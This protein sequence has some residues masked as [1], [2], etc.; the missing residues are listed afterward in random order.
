MEASTAIYAPLVFR[1]KSDILSGRFVPGQM[2]G[3]EVR[4][5]AEAGISR[6]SVRLAIDDLVQE[7]LVERRAGKGIFARKAPPGVRIVELVV[8]E[9]GSHLWA[10][11][12]HGAQ[13]AG[14]QQGIKLQI[15]NAN[16]DFEADVRAIR[17]LPSSGVDGA[18]IAALHQKRMNET[19]VQLWQTGFPFVMCD[20]RM[21]D[22]DVPSVIFDNRHAGY[23]ATQELITLGHRR[24]GFLGYEV[25]GPT[26][27]RLEGYRDALNAAGILFD[28][29]L[30]AIQSL[31]SADAPRT[32]NFEEFLATLGARPDRPTAIVMHTEQ[33]A[34]LAYPLMKKQGLRIPDDISVISIGSD[35][36]AEVLD[37]SL[38]TVI[39][40]CREMGEAAIE[41][42]VKRLQDPTAPIEHRVLPV[43]WVARASVA[44][45][46]AKSAREC[47]MNATSR[48]NGGAQ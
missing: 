39:L 43:K 14:T 36:H 7:G 20:Q 42:L 27:S 22:I 48:T 25:S 5:A 15:Y 47:R 17:R 34:F 28:R 3:T 16:L 41:I 19:L 46:R 12:A 45:V 29:S 2:L 1:L 26:G 9:L 24:I 35:E 37:P 4:L 31:D 13:D 38:A 10:E 30:T 11:V 33:L 44:K 32:P 8:Q 40:P 18:I 6:S 21:Q 23:L